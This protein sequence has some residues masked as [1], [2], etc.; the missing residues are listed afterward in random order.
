MSQNCED[1]E[2]SAGA[3][4]KGD[5]G[6]QRLDCAGAVDR[7]NAFFGSGRLGPGFFCLGIGLPSFYA[8]LLSAQGF[9][10]IRITWDQR[11]SDSLN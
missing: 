11:V 7:C 6:I 5:G 8:W 2:A 10:T 3:S 9:R 1:V 4:E